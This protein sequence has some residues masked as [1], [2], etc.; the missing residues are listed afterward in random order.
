MARPLSPPIPG[1]GQHV[2]EIRQVLGIAQLTLAHLLGVSECAVSRW[3][4]GHMNPS[5]AH[6]VH[7]CDLANERLKRKAWTP[8]RLMNYV[9]P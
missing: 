5:V 6:M 3:E 8:N 1:L 4:N 9:W 2:I 7:M